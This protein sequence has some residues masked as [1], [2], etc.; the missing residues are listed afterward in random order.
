M[1]VLF[2]YEI[3]DEDGFKAVGLVTI[4]VTPVNDPPFI[5]NGAIQL[6]EGETVT[7]DFTTGIQ[8]EEYTL[9]LDN[10]FSFKIIQGPSKG[11]AT[12]TSAGILTYTAP[13]YLSGGNPFNTSLMYEYTDGGGLTTTNIVPIT[14]ANSVPIPVADTFYVGVNQTINISAANG[15]LVNDPSPPVTTGVPV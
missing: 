1:F 15:V 14:I 2:S 4:C 13:D 8:D 10:G 3:E 12:L 9:G 11:V 5:S 6:N 7:R